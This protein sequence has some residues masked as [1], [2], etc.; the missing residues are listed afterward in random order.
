MIT[1]VAHFDA[2][3]VGQLVIN[4]RNVTLQGIGQGLQDRPHA[5]QFL[6]DITQ[7]TF[8]VRCDAVVV[9]I[10]DCHSLKTNYPIAIGLVANGLAVADPN[11]SAEFHKWQEYARQGH[12][13]VWA[14]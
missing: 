9:A 11:S 7:N 10:Y 4:G 8:E 14:R 3:T 1:G 2:N 6:A 13:G 12:R 5:E